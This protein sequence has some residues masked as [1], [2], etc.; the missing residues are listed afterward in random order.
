MLFLKSSLLTLFFLILVLNLCFVTFNFQY[1]YLGI[2][3]SL[4]GIL[5]L[6]NL[7]ITFRNRDNLI[8]T[9][10]FSGIVVS[11]F[12]AYLFIKF[13]VWLDNSE[14]NLSPMIKIAITGGAIAVVS[15]VGKELGTQ[16]WN[17]CHQYFVTMCV[18]KN[19]QNPNLFQYLLKY[20]VANRDKLEIQK[21]RIELIQ[22]NVKKTFWTHTINTNTPTVCWTPDNGHHLFYYNYEG[23]TYKIILDISSEI[24]QHG[25][26]QQ[27][28]PFERRVLKMFILG[29]NRKH[30]LLDLCEKARLDYFTVLENYTAIM[31]P[32]RWGNVWEQD[33][34]VEKENP[35]NYFTPLKNK[36]KE[37]CKRFV[38]GEEYFNMSGKDYRLCLMFHG[39]SGNGKTK[40][41]RVLAS[42]LNYNHI[43]SLNLEHEHITT[44]NVHKLIRDTPEKSIIL[45]ED[46]HKD[47]R[48]LNTSTLLNLLDGVTSYDKKIFI[49]TTNNID[50]ISDSIKRRC[51][52]HYFFNYA[53]NSQIKDILNFYYPGISSSICNKFIN[54]LKDSKIRLS[55]LNS[56]LLYQNIISKLP[57]RIILEDNITE[58]VNKSC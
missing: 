45:I 32:D 26:G 11:N 1:I 25:V 55:D 6:I 42:Y 39:P 15:K 51:D 22:T 28:A 37:K 8:F 3:Y 24:S 9:I 13:W 48:L 33:K 7:F 17:W 19:L 23:V 14:S 52:S 21:A 43:C 4:V 36:I 20:F 29:R 53:N 38:V 57:E 35:N 18:I 30:I 50:E 10:I 56:Y 2:S 27:G 49:I 44:A 54:Y 58:L 31:T 12:L 46:V 16:I 40:M 47:S 34:L 5:F 41:V